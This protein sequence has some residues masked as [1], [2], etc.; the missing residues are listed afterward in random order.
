ME[1]GLVVWKTFL[2]VW[3]ILSGRK[4]AFRVRT[5]W[6]NVKHVYSM[7]THLRGMASS[8][9]HTS[10]SHVPHLLADI[11]PHRTFLPCR[12][13]VCIVK[14]CEMSPWSVQFT[15]LFID[16][17]FFSCRILSLVHTPH[18]IGLEHVLLYIHGQFQSHHPFSNPSHFFFFH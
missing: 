5:L 10:L 11:L 12:T 15:V 3:L 1:I 18:P 4:T 7:L 8:F 17:F 14:K 13:A 9:T 16:Q 6:S 2:S